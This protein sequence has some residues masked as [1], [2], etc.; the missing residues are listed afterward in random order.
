MCYTKYYFP[1]QPKLIHNVKLKNLIKNKKFIGS[2][3]LSELQAK[4]IGYPNCIV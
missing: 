3:K 1:N 2:K 4:S